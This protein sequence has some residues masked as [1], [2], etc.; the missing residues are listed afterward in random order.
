MFLRSIAIALLT[1]A[2]AMPAALAQYPTKPVRIVVPYPPGG[3]ADILGR[4]LSQKLAER[5][6]Q[7]AVVDNRGGAT[8]MIGTE[9]VVNAVPDGYTVLLSA[10]Q[11]IVINPNIYKKL[12]YDPQKDLVP[13][14]LVARAPNVFV[15]HPSLPVASLKEFIEHAGRQPGKLT[16]A[17]SGAGSSQHIA[18]EVLKALGKVNLVHVPYKGG[19]PQVA[20]LLGGE[21]PVAFIALPAAVGA[22]RQGRMKALGVTATA[23]SPALPEVPTM[24]EAGVPVDVDQW[25]AIFLPAKTPSAIATKLNGDF[26]WALK[27]PDV[28]SRMIDLGYE[29]HGTT[30]EQFSEFVRDQTARYR[31]IIQDTKIEIA[32]GS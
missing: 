3:G 17:S 1:L 16:Y 14:T 15:T 28:R 8:G 9:I 29:P 25:Y 12:R 6:G 11:E 32:A 27:L 31:K 5:W 26:V 4:T 2:A 18:G 24:A 22:V 7:P 23:R 20:A 10:S 13:V 30:R 21:T 19:G